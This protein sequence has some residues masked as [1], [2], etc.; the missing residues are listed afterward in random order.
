MGEI[1]A[2]LGRALQAT[3]GR[4]ASG[5]TLDVLSAQVSLETAHGT[6]MYNYNFGGIKGVSPHG[7]TANYMTHEVMDGQNVALSQG[8]RAYRSLDEGAKDYVAV[9]QARFP[10]ALSSAT[11]GDLGGFAHAL[12]EAHYYTASEKEYAAGLQAAAPASSGTGPAQSP[13]EAPATEFSTSAEL[14]RVIDAVSATAVHIA[15]PEPEG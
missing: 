8:F 4:A 13:I 3:T 14:S 10:G 7:E 9:L 12:K 1:R 6:Q 11:H 15:D 5:K 2:A